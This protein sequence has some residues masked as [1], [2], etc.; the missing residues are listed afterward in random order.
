MF[1]DTFVHLSC[2]V[3]MALNRMLLRSS[4][5][6]GAVLCR[7]RPTWTTAVMRDDLTIFDDSIQ[8]DVGHEIPWQIN[9]ITLDQYY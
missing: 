8:N 7:E 4:G 5:T 1:I 9:H 3:L 2:I 6:I